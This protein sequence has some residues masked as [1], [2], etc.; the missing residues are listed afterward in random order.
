VTAAVAV[1]AD[2]RDDW[3]CDRPCP[4]CDSAPAELLNADT[5]RDAWLAAR[6]RGI[7]SSE[8]SAVMSI[9]PWES[10]FSL[11]WRKVNGWDLDLSAEMEWGT[12]LEAAVAQKYVDEHDEWDVRPA[13]LM[14][15]YEPW[16]LA[17]PDR[18]IHEH[19]DTP[20]RM[21][22]PTAVLEVKTGHSAADG[23]GPA[24][25]DDIPVY[26]RAQVQWQMAVVDVMWADV[27]VLIGGSDYREYTILR[28][29]KDIAVMV[30]YGRRFMA[31]LD[32]GDP[33]PIDDHTATV[34][35][36]RRLHPDLDDTEVEVPADV[37]AGYRRACRMQSTAEKVKK[38]YEAQ[39]R[40]AMGRARKATAAGAFVASRSI[41]S[42][43]EHT[44]AEH[45]VDRLNPARAAVK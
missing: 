22:H 2:H 37:A 11:Y 18:T 17:T 8:I 5:D 23:W 16:M 31:R 19:E 9:S 3:P 4:A 43:K 29:E 28:D 7:G 15:G 44:V 39:L 12:R 21:D 27:A 10:P 35:T 26:Y 34:A 33:P 6:R 1:P 41:Y 14:V 13:G 30:E 20:Y 45:M 32:A 36:L 42:V 24:G 38:R 40:A 25:G